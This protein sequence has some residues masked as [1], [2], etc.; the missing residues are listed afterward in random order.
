MASA[1]FWSRSLQNW[2]SGL[3]TVASVAILF[4][5]L[6]QRGSPES[7]PVGT[8]HSATGIEGWAR[9]PSATGW[10]GSELGNR[11]RGCGGHA[12]RSGETRRPGVGRIGRRPPASEDGHGAPGP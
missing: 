4:V 10:L 3:P 5:Y 1:D 7:R 2:Q 6:R 8:P 11:Q 9:R 12:P